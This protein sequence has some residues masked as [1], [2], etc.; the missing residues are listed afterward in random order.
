MP[1]LSSSHRSNIR[2]TSA[3]HSSAVRLLGQQQPRSMP[4]QQ[5]SNAF[6][7]T[8]IRSARF[9]S[10]LRQAIALHPNGKACTRLS[11]PL[12]RTSFRRST[13]E[14]LQTM[15]E[16]TKRAEVRRK[17]NSDEAPDTGLVSATQAVS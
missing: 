15:L 17:T 7:G 4:H 9:P 11:A 1:L 2:G 16:L 8:G 13:E 12:A 5:P 3:G 10:P 14:Q 6:P